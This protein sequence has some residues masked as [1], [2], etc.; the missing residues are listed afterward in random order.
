MPQ[1]TNIKRTFR[2]TLRGSLG[3]VEVER[4]SEKVKAVQESERAGESRVRLLCCWVTIKP[5]YL[6]TT[7]VRFVLP[8]FRH[9]DIPIHPH[10]HANTHIHISVEKFWSARILL[11]EFCAFYFVLCLLLCAWL[12]FVYCF[13]ILR[14]YSQFEGEPIKWRT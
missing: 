13:L 11:L 10:T 7:R 9:A 2:A 1:T 8:T 12:L 6:M 3:A 4:G 5:N 14:R